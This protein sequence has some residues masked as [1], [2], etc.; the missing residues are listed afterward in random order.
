MTVKEALQKHLNEKVRI[1]SIYWDRVHPAETW[2]AVLD[3]SILE[4]ECSTIDESSGYFNITYAL[5]IGLNETIQE[6]GFQIDC[7]FYDPK[8]NLYRISKNGKDAIAYTDT[9]K[10]AYLMVQE[11]KEMRL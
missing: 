6:S 10:E 7:I 5:Y 1:N 3:N 11:L 9:L 8:E 4:R 2:L